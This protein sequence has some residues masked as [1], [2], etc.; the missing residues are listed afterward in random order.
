MLGC[1]K[2]GKS[3]LDPSRNDAGE[4][5]QPLANIPEIVC[6]AWFFRASLVDCNACPV[7]RHCKKAHHKKLKQAEERSEKQDSGYGL[8]EI[9][10]NAA[11]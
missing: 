2:T 1:K 11:F 8:S 5:R 6:F 9:Y 4:R 3:T 10:R 7:V